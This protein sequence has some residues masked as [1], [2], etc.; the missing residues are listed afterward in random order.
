M[1][2]VMTISVKIIVVQTSPADNVNIDVDPNRV[3]QTSA[4]MFDDASNI[5]NNK[6]PIAKALTDKIAISAS[7]LIFLFWL[8]F[9]NRIAQMIV[10]GITNNELF[11]RFK[12]AAIAIVPN[13]V[14]DSPS[15]I[16][17]NRFNT[18]ITPNRAAHNEIK[19]PTIRAYRTNGN[20]R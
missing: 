19:I 11:E 16:Y 15:P 13:A 8:V 1:K 9:S 18:N 7:P 2:N 12:T 5:F 6:Y 17:E 4:E 20:D 3:V 10:T 14:W